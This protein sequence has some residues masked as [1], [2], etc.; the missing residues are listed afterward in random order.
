MARVRRSVRRKNP[1]RPWV[2]TEERKKREPKLVD[3][4]EPIDV[5]IEKAEEVESKK[6]NKDEAGKEEA[7]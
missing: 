6:K 7:E 1:G 3:G 4:R 2:E 5:L